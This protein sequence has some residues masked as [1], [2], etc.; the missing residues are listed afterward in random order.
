MVLESKWG[1]REL[2]EVRDEVGVTGGS[3]C[4]EC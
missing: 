3:E 4:V 1:K 2:S